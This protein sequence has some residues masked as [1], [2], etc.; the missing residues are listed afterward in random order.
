[1]SIAVFDIDGVVADV[2]HRLHFLESRPKDWPGFFRAADA[3]LPMP[4]GMDLVRELAP[5]H[6][7]VW[8]TGRPEWLRSVTRS[9]L[10]DH[11]MPVSKLLMRPTHDYRPARIVKVEALRRLSSGI[12]IFVDDDADVI[13]AAEAAGFPAR[14]AHW[15]SRSD[16]LTEAQERTG[17]T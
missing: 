8:L 10:A 9:W 12:A 7:I 4:E 14:L 17:R 13:A 5:I 2:R 16:V 11:G 6:D 1:V 15:Q 3:D